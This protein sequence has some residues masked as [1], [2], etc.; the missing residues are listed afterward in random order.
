M[1]DSDIVARD[2]VAR[3]IVVR[4]GDGAAGPVRVRLAAA[5][6]DAR[7]GKKLLETIAFALAAP[8]AGTWIAPAD[9]LGLGSGFAWAAVP[10]VV[11]AARYGSVWGVGCALVAILGCWAHAGTY[12]ADPFALVALAVGML[13]TTLAVGEIGLGWR[14][15]AAG[16]EAGAAY[17][18]RRLQ[19]FSNE[20]HVLKVSHGLLQESLAGRA[21]SLREALQGL[22]RAVPR[23]SVDGAAAGFGSGFA[24]NAEL[25]A[26]FARF[27]SIQVAS[28]H[29][30]RSPGAVDP[31]PIAT[32]GTAEPLPLFDPLLRTAIAE[33]RTTSVRL[34]APALEADEHGLLA[35]VPIVD[36]P[37]RVHGVL[38]VREMHFMAFQEENLN[39]MALLGAWLGDRFGRAGGM[40]QTPAEHFVAEL[41]AALARVREHG[42]PATLVCLRT[43]HDERAAEVAAAIAA[44]IRSLDRAWTATAP[45][46]VPT[47]TLLLPLA[48]AHDAEDYASRMLSA[49]RARFGAD[50]RTLVSSLRVRALGPADTRERCLGFIA[51]ATGQGPIEGPTEGRGPSD[52]RGADAAPRRVA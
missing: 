16:A 12:A 5:R 22:E 11:L 18:A 1:A 45:D 43:G 39:L 47:V 52:G 29:A 34:D 10:P 49:V 15:R 50:P 25:M 31:T 3:D 48:S 38:A 13:V 17:L 42:V 26:V 14:R 36:A 21:M 46:G 51:G 4:D 7:R 37:G 33:R 20:H 30:M 35:V 19:E 24:G 32:H 23:G 6:A 41:D 27:C 44:D 40:G 9:P 28:L 8:L 2:T